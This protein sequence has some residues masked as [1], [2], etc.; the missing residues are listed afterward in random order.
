MKYYI[1][2]LYIWLDFF[3]HSFFKIL[4]FFVIIIAGIPTAIR[5]IVIPKKTVALIVSISNTIWIKYMENQR[6]VKSPKMI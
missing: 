4:G 1:G 6:Q 2:T 5:D 3:F